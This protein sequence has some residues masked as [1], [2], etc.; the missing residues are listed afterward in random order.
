MSAA[1]NGDDIVDSICTALARAI[2]DG[3]LRPGTKIAEDVVAK[4]FGVS[5]TVARGAVTILER[6]RLVERRRNHGAFVASPDEAQASQLLEA[7]RVLE[8]AIVSRAVACASDEDLCALEALTRD[9]DA[10]HGGSDPAAK[11]R[12]HGNFHIELS[13][14]AGNVVVTDML[15]NVVARLSLVA[16]LYERERAHRCGADDHR[17][18][19]DAI[20][21]RDLDGARAQMLRH[22]D[23]LERMLD[24]GARLDD[25]HSLSAVLEKFAP[26]API[27]HR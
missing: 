17:L 26:S 8:V 1:Q 5:R 14:C 21:R 6:E 9:E 7:R 18:I 20:R 10:V 19:L 11:R 22:L 16:A 23:D 13:R 15:K 4:H 27:E 12:I 2:S 25:Q 24:L 3:A